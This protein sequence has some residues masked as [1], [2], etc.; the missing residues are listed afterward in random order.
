VPEAALG[1]M[2]RAGSHYAALGT[3]V[4]LLARLFCRPLAAAVVPEALA[5]TADALLRCRWYLR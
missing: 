1:L 4:S 5:D 2:V 3:I